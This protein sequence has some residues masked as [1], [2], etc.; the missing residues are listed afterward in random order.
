MTTSTG[1]HGTDTKHLYEVLRI[2]ASWRV[3]VDGEPLRYR[4]GLLPDVIRTFKTA[5]SACWHAELEAERRAV[6][7]SRWAS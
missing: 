2:G 4:D 7:R 6:E 3:H 1:Y 5:D